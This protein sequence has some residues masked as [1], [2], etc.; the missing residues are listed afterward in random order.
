VRGQITE[1]LAI[2]NTDSLMANFFLFRN[3][4]PKGLC[5]TGD[6]AVIMFYGFINNFIFNNK[7]KINFRTRVT[8]TE[9]PAIA[10]TDSLREIYKLYYKKL[11]HS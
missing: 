9:Y 2:A 7:I 6:I 8:E 10:N 3:V 1:Y 5:L 4:A 11:F